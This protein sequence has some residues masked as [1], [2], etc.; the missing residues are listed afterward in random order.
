MS[1]EEI[2]VPL[3]A[4]V[5]ERARARPSGSTLIVG[6]CGAQ[7]SGKS[8]AAARVLSSLERRG[9]NALTV[10]LDDFYLPSADRRRLAATVHPLLATRGVPGTHDVELA[11]EVL[12]ATRVPGEVRVPRFDKAADDRR[13]ESEWPCVRGPLDVV[14]FEGWCVGARPEEPSSLNTPVNDLERD[15]DPD[16]TWRRH[17]NDALAGAYQ[18]LFSRLDALVLLA[19]PGFEVVTR[20]R[21]EP[22]EE[23]R[24]SGRAGSAMDDAELARFI[25]HYERITRHILRE[26]PARADQTLWLDEDRRVVSSTP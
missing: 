1:R 15:E 4:F 9:R 2:A 8:T 18:D 10:S 6:V 17:V 19:A 11:M 25:A 3:E 16:G 22:E 7:G 26:M 23:L 24:R 12:D 20:W 14:I 21:K 13:P 5:E